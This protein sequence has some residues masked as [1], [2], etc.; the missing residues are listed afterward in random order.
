M[1]KKA[2]VKS[3]G[4]RWQDHVVGDPLVEIYPMYLKYLHQRYSSYCEYK[5]LIS[6]I[7]IMVIFIAVSVGIFLLADYINTWEMANNYPYGKLCDV[8][9]S[10]PK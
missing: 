8:F 2:K 1:V 4:L 9:N 3:M 6:F 7:G 10:C 5:R